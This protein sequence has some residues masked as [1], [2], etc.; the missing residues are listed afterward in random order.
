MVFIDYVRALL[1]IGMILMFLIPILSI[2]QN[3]FKKQ[4]RNR[5]DLL[6]LTGVFLCVVP[7]GLYSQ[8]MDYYVE[9]LIMYLPFLLLPIA[10]VFLKPLSSR[11]FMFIYY[12]FLLLVFGISVQAFINYLMHPAQINELYL[13]S[14]VMPTITLNDSDE[15]VSF[16]LML[17]LAI[18]IAY[19][20][21]RHQF[22]AFHRAER[23]LISIAGLFL[24][25]FIHVFSVRGGILVLYAL[26]LME[27]YRM[28]FIRKQVKQ[29]IVILSSCLV[30]GIIAWS[31]VPTIRNKVQNTQADLDAMRQ[32][33]S[34]NNLS[35]SSRKVSYEMAKSCIISSPWFGCGLGDL[36]DE[37]ESY[38]KLNHP[39]ITKIII[40]HNQLL[41]NLAAIG[42]PATLV[43][44]FCLLYPLFYRKNYK[45]NLLNGQYILLL[46]A[47]MFEAYFQTQL[48]VAFSLLFLLLP[49]NQVSNWSK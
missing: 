3:D 10:F 42:I 39:E 27:L 34:A 29:A 48:G 32:H 46:L 22:Y 8:N 44:L 49:L 45:N 1:S 2:R 13:H 19:Y 38:F 36:H 12:Y 30:A 4:L 25:V 9:R 14:K 40:P 47:C 24:F 6:V 31:Y 23:Y 15:H 37:C 33:K 35:L 20:L 43:W 17:A 16:S 21:F 5:K 7:S 28:M 26:I 41:Y 18:S 11:Q